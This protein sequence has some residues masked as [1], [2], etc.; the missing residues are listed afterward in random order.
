MNSVTL[1]ENVFFYNDSDVCS[2]ATLKI[3]ASSASGQYV[4]RQ[5]LLVEGRLRH[6]RYRQ[7]LPRIIGSLRPTPKQ[8]HLLRDQL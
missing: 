7:Q 2:H 4:T 6:Y 1:D 5:L 8:P 3:G